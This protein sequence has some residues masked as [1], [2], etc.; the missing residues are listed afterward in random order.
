MMVA[1]WQCF[2]D[3]TDNTIEKSSITDHFIRMLQHYVPWMTADLLTVRNHVL[4]ITYCGDL[5][6][7]PKM[8]ENE[9]I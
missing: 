2:G 6:K 5:A 9:N 8:Q 3:T 1:S 4:L 7:V